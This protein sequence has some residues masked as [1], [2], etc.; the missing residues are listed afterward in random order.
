MPHSQLSLYDPATTNSR[1]FIKQQKSHYEVE[2]KLL[3]NRITL[4]QSEEARI[5]KK[6]D[7]TRRKAEQILE[8]KRQAEERHIV[9][10]QLERQQEMQRK[11]KQ[12]SVLQNRLLQKIQNE[13]RFNSRLDQAK[14]GAME[15]KEQR[16]VIMD[17]KQHMKQ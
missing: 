7:N 10:M 15:V 9:Q 6:I 12:V 1:H 16:H 3:Q 11:S 5:L 4:L 8:I 14:D 13:R 2:Q 17:L